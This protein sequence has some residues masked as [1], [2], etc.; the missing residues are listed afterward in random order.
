[1]E[2]TGEEKNKNPGEEKK[3]EKE[4]D[5]GEPLSGFSKE[6]WKQSAPA[7]NPELINVKTKPV[8]FFLI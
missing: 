4:D 5:F 6:E 2:P 8:S 3:K 1:M 7:Y